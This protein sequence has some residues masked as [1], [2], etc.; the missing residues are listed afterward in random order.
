V[1]RT[2]IVKEAKAAVK[3]YDSHLEISTFYENQY[4]GFAQITAL[5]VNKNAKL[6]TSDAIRIAAKVPLYFIDAR[7]NILGRICLKK[8]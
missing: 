5:Y 7:G 3:A 1:K 8:R 6:S 4:I 2:L